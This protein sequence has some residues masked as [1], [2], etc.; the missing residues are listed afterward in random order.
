LGGNGTIFANVQNNGIVSPGAS[1]GT[2]EINGT[3][4]QQPGGILEI[5]VGGASAS[6]VDFLHVGVAQLDGE[7]R[8]KLIAGAVP[9]V[10]VALAAAGLAGQFDNVANGQR[11]FT[12]D[13]GGSFVVNYGPGSP[14]NPNQIVLSSFLPGING[15]FDHDGDV[16]GND[17]LVWQRGGSPQPNSAADLTAWRANFG[18]VAATASGAAVPEPHGFGLVLAAAIIAVI[19]G[20]CYRSTAA[21]CGDRRGDGLC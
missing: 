19:Q 6:H 15:D 4:A 9:A 16:D 12:V 7:L 20:R 21:D 13:G 18:F 10:N 1:I 8:L 5:E 2:L 17:I 14:F 11:L 3:F